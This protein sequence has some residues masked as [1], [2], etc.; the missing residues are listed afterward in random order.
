MPALVFVCIILV[1]I[2]ANTIKIL[3]EWERGVVLRL[4]TFQA[5]RGPGLTFLIPGISVC[6]GSIP[7]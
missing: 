7:G 4:G 6:T 5:V 3:R 1:I 2:L